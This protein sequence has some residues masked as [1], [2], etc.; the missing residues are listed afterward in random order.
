MTAEVSA[1]PAGEPAG[2]LPH[3][4]GRSPA[5]VQAFQEVYLDSFPA[6]VAY[7]TRTLHDRELA[8]ELV[9]E[10][11]TRLLTRWRHVDDPGAYAYLIVTNLIRNH[12]RSRDRERG[13][14]RSLLVIRRDVAPS[15]GGDVADAV[16]RLPAKLRDAVLLHYY[17]DRSVEEVAKLL[18]RPPGTVKR[19]LHEA[20]T[21]LHESLRE[22]TDG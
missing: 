6:L 4:L 10:A 9:Q 1:R 11:F 16:S 22:P 21:L 18:G 12:W 15:G 3:V 5:S 14:L 2:G 7:A 19:Q 20:R 17:G 8:R 13:A